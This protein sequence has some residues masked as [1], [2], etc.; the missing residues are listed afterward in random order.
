[1]KKEIVKGVWAFLLVPLYVSMG[2]LEVRDSW[3]NGNKE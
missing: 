3:R 1:M 2:S